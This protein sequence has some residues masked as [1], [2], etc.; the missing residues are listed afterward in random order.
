MLLFT[1]EALVFL[2][3]TINFRACTKGMLRLTVVSD[4]LIAALGFSMV[5]WIAEAGTVFEQVIYVA[6]A[7]VGSMIGMHLT[8]QWKEDHEG[9]QSTPQG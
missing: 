1:A 7:G 6:G 4:M 5:R 3:A 8:K 2:L 9:L